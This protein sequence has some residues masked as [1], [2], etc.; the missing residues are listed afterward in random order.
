ME[1]VISRLETLDTK[2]E[3]GKPRQSHKAENG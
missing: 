3:S 2:Y 1:D